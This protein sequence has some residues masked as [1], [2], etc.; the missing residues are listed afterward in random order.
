MNKNH[1]II[2]QKD[3]K[4]NT[5]K[6][7]NIFEWLNNGNIEISGNFKIEFNIYYILLLIVSIAICYFMLSKI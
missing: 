1:E 3:C 4:K 5:N 6:R 7:F 2:D